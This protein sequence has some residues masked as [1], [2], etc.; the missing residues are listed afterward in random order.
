MHTSALESIL[1]ADCGTTM[2]RVSLVVQVDGSYRLIAQAE[3]LSTHRRPWR[4]VA[5]GVADA[6]R[7][8]EEQTGRRIL[9]DEAMLIQPQQETLDGV[10]AFAVVTSA[11]EPLKV[12]LVGLMSQ[13]SL[14][15]AQQAIATTYA[16]VDYQAGLDDDA[17]ERG[18]LARVTALKQARPDMILLVGGVDGGAT[19]PV[20]DL[21]HQV[22]LTLRTMLP[23]DRPLVVYAGNSHLRREVADILGHLTDFKSVDNVRPSLEVEQPDQVQEV[24]QSQFTTWKIPRLPGLE[25]LAE[26]STVSARPA[27]KSIEQTIAYVGKTFGVTALG[28]DV[29][30]TTTTASIKGQDTSRTITLANIGVGASAPNVLKQTTWADF[31]RWLPF[32]L[33][34]NAFKNFVHNQNLYPQTVPQTEQEMWMT[35]ALVR[36]A[37]RLLRRQARQ[38]RA[39]ESDYESW[40]LI[41]G[42][43]YLLTR[44]ID[45]AR[46]ALALLDGLE[47]A[48]IGRLVL[49]VNGISRM[50]G[51]LALLQ[52]DAAAELID[53]GLQFGGANAFLNLG[54]VVAPV[55]ESAFGSPALR[56]Q[57]TYQDGHTLDMKIPFG[58][59]E[60]IPLSW[61]EEATLQLRPTRRFSLSPAWEQTGQALTVTITGGALGLIIDARGRPMTLARK[62]ED[63]FQQL[64]SWYASLTNLPETIAHPLPEAEAYAA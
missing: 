58:S 56:L 35:L 25:R 26:W 30:S 29:G 12:A 1:I 28:V 59:I 50:V 51:G 45:P 11:A 3:T 33:S 47:P 19:D 62:D 24:V 38:G 42:A 40:D 61:N 5:L 32:E 7:Q 63:R 60:V 2:T 4:N 64:Q 17:S 10:D 46:A 49:D 52:P 23:E 44:V 43:G 8:L 39:P 48:G 54:M 13:L 55:G 36:E 6:I 31:Q 53:Q 9:N 37:L 20:L 34:E 22:G 18:M 21:A 41:L 27:A 16:V 57:M 14:K 15:T